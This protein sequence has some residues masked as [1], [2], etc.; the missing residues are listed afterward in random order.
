MRATLF[1][2]VFTL[3]SSLG[4]S[5]QSMFDK[6]SDFD[7]DG[8]ADFAVV[9]HENGQKIW[10]LHRSTAGFIGLAWGLENDVVTAGDYDGDSKTDVAVTRLTLTPPPNEWVVTTYYLAS[11]TNSLGVVQFQTF[12]AVGSL[13][14]F[15]ED[16]DGDGKTD[17]GLFQWHAI[18]GITY[19]KSSTGTLAGVS[20]NWFQVRVGD[21]TGDNS[22]EI[23]Q[24][25]PATGEFSVVQGASYATRFGVQGDRWIAADFDGD[26]KGE[27]AIFRPSNGD[28]W[29]IRSSDNVVNALHWGINGDVPVPADYDGDGRSDHAVWRPSSPQGT[30][31][32]LG[33]AAGFSAFGFGMPTDTAVT[34]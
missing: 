7:G 34:Y 8:R 2:I 31:Y 27:I 4:V 29:W 21:L 1:A 19:K 25:Q 24:W 11:S 9:R 30:Y 23:A 14:V 16:Y 20:M 32:V 3:I 28:W 33:S 15:N 18:G 10:Y 5:S 6:V 17:V 13:G 26:N 12:N 22:A